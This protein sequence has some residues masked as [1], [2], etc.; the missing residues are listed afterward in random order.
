MLEKTIKRF[1]STL[2]RLTNYFS[3]IERVIN[4]RPLTYS[5]NDV[6]G[7]P[8]FSYSFHLTENNLI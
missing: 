8:L 5:Y 6:D 4:N 2:W 7:E 1:E 3:R